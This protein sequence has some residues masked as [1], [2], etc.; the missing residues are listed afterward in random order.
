M[1]PNEAERLRALARYGLAGTSPEERFDRIARLAAHLI[2]VPVALVTLVDADTQWYKAAVGVPAGRTPRA[3]AFCAHTILDDDVLVVED[4]ATDP[5][6]KDN[7]DVVSGIGI[8]FYAGAPIRTRDGYRLGS[9]CVIDAQPRT[10][11]PEECGVLKDLAAVAAEEVEHTLVLQRVEDRA[12]QERRDADAFIQGLLE[13]S[14]DC[15]KTLGLDGTL[16]TMNRNGCALLEIDDFDEVQGQPWHSLWPEAARPQVEAALATARRGEE[17]A[18]FAFCPTT[19]GTPKW[20]DVRV[21]AVPGAS[22]L[23]TRLVSF[24]RDVTERE[25]MLGQLRQNNDVLEARIDERTAALEQRNRDLQEFA[26]AAGHDLREPLRKIEG[27]AE[28]LRQEE[29]ARLSP[30]GQHYLGRI[31]DAVARMGR[32]L[33]DLLALAHLSTQEVV[34]AEVPLADALEDVLSDLQVR[35]NE[36]QGRVEVAT[37]LPAVEASR[38]QLHRLLLNLIGN[39]LKYHRPDVAP[40]VRVSAQRMGARVQVR[41]E[42]NGIGFEGKF[43]QEI[44]AP[45]HRLHGRGTFEGTGVGLTIVRR[46][47]ERHGGTVEAEGRPG[48]GATFTVTLPAAP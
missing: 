28:L 32:L 33:E 3:I 16:L 27:F 23:P 7:P 5:R 14:S 42:D 35:L 18:F 15:V 38:A 26:Y 46:I 31:G 20:W 45:F 37:P 43:A 25:A 48:E 34:L 41:V 8:R 30:T 36:T 6:F 22:G 13:A 21:I 44:F 39:A 29:D 40:V 1:P 19:K 10:I 2:R 24:S 17:G 4:A 47:A 11:T 9:V 12:E